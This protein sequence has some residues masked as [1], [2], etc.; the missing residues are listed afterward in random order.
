MRAGEAS[1]RGYFAWTLVDNFEWAAGY[2]LRFGFFAY[3][4]DTL[5]RS[6]RPSARLFRRI[7]RSGRLPGYPGSPPAA[8]MAS[9]A[10]W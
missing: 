2:Y 7:A 3:D 10:S 1:V 5:A 9:R 6:E 4:P 8:A